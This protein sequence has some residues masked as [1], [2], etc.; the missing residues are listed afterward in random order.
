[1]GVYGNV[2]VRK[3]RGGFGFHSTMVNWIMQCDTTASFTLNVNREKIG[4]FKGD[5]LLV[6]CHGDTTS[7]KVIKKAL[8]AFSTCSGLLPNNSKRILFFGS[9]KEEDKNDVRFVLPFVTGKLH[10]RYL[11]VPLIVKRLGVKECGCL[12]D[13]IKSMIQNWNNKYLSY[14]GRLQLIATVLESIHVY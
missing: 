4:Y 1:M 13:K 11:G 6:M 5:D 10:V 14:A 12:L 8:D 9:M 2:T 3:I 7:V